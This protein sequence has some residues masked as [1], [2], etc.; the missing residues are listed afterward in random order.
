M[1]LVL[2]TLYVIHNLMQTQRKWEHQSNKMFYVH[3]VVKNCQRTNKLFF[4]FCINVNFDLHM[5]FVVWAENKDIK[6]E[7]LKSWI[8]FWTNL[9]PVSKVIMMQHCLEWVHHLCKRCWWW[10][11]P[12]SRHI[13]HQYYLRQYPM[14]S[15]TNYV[16]YS[17]IPHPSN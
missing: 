16:V 7:T 5:N 2:E 6:Q 13:Q 15:N 1:T 17:R 14:L 12:Y 10:T 11:H 8:K 3:C 4:L 9:L